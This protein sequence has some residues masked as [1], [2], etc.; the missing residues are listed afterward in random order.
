VGYGGDWVAEQRT[1]VGVVS[2]GYGDGYSR[3]LSNQGEVLIHGQRVPLIGRVSMDTI[4]LNLNEVEL[5]RVGDEVILWGDQNL[6]VEFLAERAQTIPYELVT[7]ICP[8]VQRV[9]S[10][11]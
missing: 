6:P 2:I 3:H 7:V 9:E 1:R 10:D 11:G 8:R 4:C 5:A